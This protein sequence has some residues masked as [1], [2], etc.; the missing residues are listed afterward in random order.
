MPSAIPRWI[1]AAVTIFGVLMPPQAVA[2]PFPDIVRPLASPIDCTKKLTK[3][4]LEWDLSLL[5]KKE[6]KHSSTVEMPPTKNRI[7]IIISICSELTR[8]TSTA[9]EDFCGSGVFMCEVTTN[10]KTGKDDRVVSVRP[11]GKGDGVETSFSGE[12]EGLKEKA[13]V[14][15]IY[16]GG[17]YKTDDLKVNL[18]ITCDTSSSTAVGEPVVNPTP[19]DPKV[20][21]VTLKSAAGCP[22]KAGSG[23]GDDGGGGGKKG[24]SGFGV[25]M[26]IVFVGIVA[27]FVVGAAYK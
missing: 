20:L 19:A 2:S 18:T 4:G 10:I 6:L 9:E 3:D 17:R 22:K 1:L 21:E 8:P 5:N 27:Y 11:L 14:N 25:F 12:E 23:G 13:W 26:T 16:G 7:D 24:M 15:L